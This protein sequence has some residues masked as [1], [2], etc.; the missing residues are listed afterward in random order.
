LLPNYGNCNL[1]IVLSY[2]KVQEFTYGPSP[3]YHDYCSVPHIFFR[4]SQAR[5]PSN[6]LLHCASTA[7]LR[8]LHQPLPIAVQK[9][10]SPW[11]AT[12]G[13]NLLDPTSMNTENK[14]GIIQT[15]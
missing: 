5:L 12:P 9:R 3:Q 2:Q 1:P 11:Q 4:L 6:P 10:I 13:F 7:A 14:A 15:S 8:H